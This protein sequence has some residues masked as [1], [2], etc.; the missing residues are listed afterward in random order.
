LPLCQID[1]RRRFLMTDPVSRVPSFFRFD[2]SSGKLSRCP[3]F[4]FEDIRQMDSAELLAPEVD[5]CSARVG[6]ATSLPC[7]GKVES[8]YSK[9]NRKGTL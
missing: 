5:R 6:N 1:L 4:E 7:S 3:H 2:I 8:Q 9:N